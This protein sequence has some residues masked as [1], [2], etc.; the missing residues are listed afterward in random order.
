MIII[1]L[2]QILIRLKENVADAQSVQ[3]LSHSIW[4]TATDKKSLEAQ[5][6]LM[7]LAD[8]S[9]PWSRGAKSFR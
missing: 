6:V 8:S 5:D 9:P 1:M 2:W 7:S 3:T 4:T